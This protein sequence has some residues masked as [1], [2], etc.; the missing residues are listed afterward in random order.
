MRF[1]SRLCV[2][3]A[4]CAACAGTPAGARAT[5]RFLAEVVRVV[6]TRDRMTVTGRYDFAGGAPREWLPLL[7]P[8][9]A[10]TALGSPRAIAAQMVGADGAVPLR[11]SGDASGVNLGVPLDS[12][13]RGRLEVSYEQRLLG[14]RATYLLTTARAWGRPLDRASLEV[15]WPHD[16]GSPRFSLPLRRFTASPGT[17]TYRFVAAP[18]QPETDLVVEW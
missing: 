7:Y 14:R 6:I 1:A 13:G 8:F 5:P 9:P 18:F 15:V 11:W 2:A 4:A 16:L 3:L 17:T 10:D 12:S